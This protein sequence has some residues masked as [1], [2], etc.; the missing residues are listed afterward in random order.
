M[1][2]W[3]WGRR[4][5]PGRRTL[6]AGTVGGAA[7]AQQVSGSGHATATHGGIAVTGI[8]NDHSSVVL[9][10]EAVRPVGEV[11][12]RPGLDNL[13]YRTAHFV[14]R[15]A[16][17]A[18]LDAVLRKPGG[19][20]LQ[21][22]HGLGGV[23]KSTLAVHWAATRARRHR[24]APVRW[25][26]ADSAASVQQGLAALATALQPAASK[27]LTVEALAENG[28]QWLATHSGW[29]LILDNVN[30]LADI[31]PLLARTPGGRF[32][33]TSRLA[34]VW[35]D[36]TEVIRLDALQPAESVALLT[37]VAGGGRDLSGAAE[38]CA[39]LGHLPLA[40]E[41]AAACLAENP[42][43]TPR[44]YL[45]L[46]RRNP[47]PLYRQGGEGF[48]VAE[49]TV[50]RVWRVTLD[51]IGERQALAADLLRTLAWYAP[52]GI[53]AGLL[54]GEGEPAEVAGAIGTLNAYSMI[55]VDPAT[56]V[57]S[58]HRLVQS[59][60]RTA[61]ADDPHR[62]PGLV[63]AARERAT[64]TLEA[65]VRPTDWQD[66]ATWPA[67]R[68][69][70]PHMD[71][72]ADH[73][74]RSADTGTTARVLDHAGVF[75]ISQGLGTRATAHLGRAL[76]HHERELGHDDIHTLTCRH[77][78]AHAYEASGH[79][80]QAIPL[81]ERV[82]RDGERVL[83]P[84]HRLTL[85]GRNNLAD[86]YRA[87][88]D[89]GRA[90]A[91]LGE[92]P[93][94]GPLPD[95]LPGAPG[96]GT[97]LPGLAARNTL[98]R[99][100]QA[101]GRHD[102]AVRLYQEN[103]DACVRALGQDHHL[104]L[105]ARSNLTVA[106]V[107]SK[108]PHEAVRLLAAIAGDMERVLGEEH[109]D[110]LLAR[111]NLAGAHR[112]AGE[113]DRSV[114]LFDEVLPVMERVLGED[115][116]TTRAARV[117]LALACRAAGDPDRAVRLA[118]ARPEPPAGDGTA[119]HRTGPTG[120][121]AVAAGA[122]EGCRP[123][124]HGSDIGY[125][126]LAAGDAER[127]VPLL[128]QAVR[129]HRHR[130]GEDD[131][132]ALT[133]RHNLAVAHLMAGAPE[134]A[135]PLFEQVLRARERLLGEDHPDTLTSRRHLADAHREA[136]DHARAVPLYEHTFRARS[137]VL[138][139]HHGDT[140][141]VLGMLAHTHRLAGRPDRAAPLFEQA[142]QAQQRTHGPHHPETLALRNSLAGTYQEAGELRRAVLLHEENA[143]ACAH[144]LGDDHAHTLTARHNLA[145]AHATSGDFGRAL[146]LLGDTYR[147]QRGT[148]GA[149]H[150]DT[151]ATQLS[152]AGMCLT[153][154]LRR[155]ARRLYKQ[156]LAT[157][158]RTLGESHP[159]TRDAHERLTSAERSG[160]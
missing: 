142:L 159:L 123:G 152:L 107:A 111:A 125:G 23:G 124:V 30:H 60:A 61:D 40:V 122:D 39:E 133:D 87:A 100:R 114:A 82:L 119:A 103:L 31:A 135:V 63:T 41:Q 130:P 12:A 104:T 115:H 11:K 94:A 56:R 136:G 74:P 69:L 57:L 144:V 137:R 24:L 18:R 72:L 80:K 121:G 21:A 54:D 9:P 154:G 145:V 43:L 128:E 102:E 19:V 106:R 92:P 55:T 45:D 146:P 34:T 75:L 118:T 134:R 153:I 89:P 138:G 70:L 52:E 126:L 59:V 37:R 127:A 15:A 67:G 157:C 91:L 78:L 113:P 140:L 20:W 10:P 143:A 101:A 90:L 65:A 36:A 110:T 25:I 29:L 160:R 62:T 28:M 1:A 13:P 58:V 48:T 116:G 68:A 47:G 14:G 155:R 38:L 131:P 117:A 132:G 71:A 7:P 5:D 76:A 129:D 32:L 16:E 108:D 141:A 2:K 6:A 112:E 22:V 77:N 88:G 98:A 35:H 150:P 81:Y 99:A 50:A 86:A 8:Y 97:D 84:A 66:P 156:T 105:V 73:T 44:T 95:P 109:P 26:P 51:R 3:R 4:R 151:L 53:P 27:A 120:P 139:A 147:R 49:R 83:G 93:G 158:R 96:G 33:I 149:D 64:A 46:L 79:V 148:L 17:L 42:L 85:A